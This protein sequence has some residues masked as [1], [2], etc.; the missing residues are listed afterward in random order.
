MHRSVLRKLRESP[1]A[2]RMAQFAGARGSGQAGNQLDSQIQSELN[3]GQAQVPDC[4]VAL[5]V[6]SGGMLSCIGV[7]VLGRGGA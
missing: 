7:V 6:G 5:A 4:E 2:G 3:A 1:A